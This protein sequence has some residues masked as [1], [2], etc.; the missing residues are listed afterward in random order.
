MTSLNLKNYILNLFKKKQQLTQL[1]RAPTM[2]SLAKLTFVWG[3]QNTNHTKV[4]LKI[5]TEEKKKTTKQPLTKNTELNQA[6]LF[7]SGKSMVIFQS[8]ESWLYALQLSV[9]EGVQTPNLS[10]SQMITWLGTALGWSP[11]CAPSQPGYKSQGA[12]NACRWLKTNTYL[13]RK[14]QTAI[15]LPGTTLPK[16]SSCSREQLDPSTAASR[17]CRLQSLTRVRTGH[18]QNL[19]PP[20]SLVLTG[21]LCKVWINPFHPDTYSSLS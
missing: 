7:I 17:W 12:R 15:L 3:A 8:A 20:G 10:S 14:V 9:A 1:I 4:A 13:G 21:V 18:S 16:P 11:P 2:P 5:Y 19:T 6:S